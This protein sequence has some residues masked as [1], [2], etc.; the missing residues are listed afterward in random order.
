MKNYSYMTLFFCLTT[1]I[2]GSQLNAFDY[3][4]TKK[5]LNCYFWHINQRIFKPLYER[6]YKPINNHPRLL[7][8]CG[9]GLTGLYLLY[10]YKLNL[11]TQKKHALRKA[12]IKD[13]KN[14]SKNTD[15][16]DVPSLKQ[17]GGE[18]VEINYND[19]YLFTSLIPKE[20]KKSEESVFTPSQKS[21]FILDMIAKLFD[22]SKK[23]Q[24]MLADGLPYTDPYKLDT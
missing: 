8:G 19:Y 18:L 24:E 11:D 15:K 4:D 20:T 2:A 10:Q 1:I 3:N 9:V 16:G 7:L 22:K 6:M 13:P 14:W 17:F 12:N 23:L 5:Q 21:V